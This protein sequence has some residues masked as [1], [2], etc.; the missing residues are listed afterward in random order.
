MELP[1]F[2]FPAVVSVTRG[3]FF[4]IRGLQSD[5]MNRNEHV[6]WP[7][8]SSRWNRW[9]VRISKRSPRS[10]RRTAGTWKD[11]GILRPDN[12][13]RHPGYSIP[14]SALFFVIT[15]IRNAQFICYFSWYRSV[16]FICGVPPA[17]WLQRPC[18][19]DL[20][21]VPCQRISLLPGTGREEVVRCRNCST[22]R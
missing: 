11:S 4:I 12:P 8:T 19:P 3:F 5:S 16:R 9:I 15:G 6:P 14:G 20:W 7:G 1:Y 18:H 2:R 17:G 13:G 10:C 22:T 21:Q